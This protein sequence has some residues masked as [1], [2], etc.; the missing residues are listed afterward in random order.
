[1]AKALILTALPMEARAIIRALGGE[2]RRPLPAS[3]PRR[4]P[5]V[6]VHAI[7]VAANW[8]SDLPRTD[9]GCVLMA[10]LAGA[11]DPSL[12]IGDIVVDGHA[13]SVAFPGPVRAGAIHTSPT[14]IATPAEKAALFQ[15][16]GAL[17]VDMEQSV[18]RAFADSL[19]VPFIGIRAISDT[20]D[21]KLDSMV[22][23]FLDPLGHVNKG[24]LFGALLRRPTLLFTLIRLGSHSRFALRNLG[25]AVVHLLDAFRA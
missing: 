14:L 23:Q 2:S 11:L 19:D 20:A 12:R 1:M 25:A 8:L 22:L 9:V 17:A 13:G 5:V 7:G 24:V 6:E 18:A 15:R 10:G 4:T 16:T 3:F 21:Q